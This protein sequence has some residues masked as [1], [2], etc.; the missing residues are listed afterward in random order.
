M[1]RH[2]RRLSL[3]L[4]VVALVPVALAQRSMAQNAASEDL[5][6]RQYESGLQ[7]LR[8]QKYT[9]ALKDFQTVVERY[10]GSQVAHAALLQV[11]QFYVDVARDA[12]AAKAALDSLLERYAMSESA[13]LAQV[14][15]GRVALAQSRTPSSIEAALAAF[16]RVPR[17]FPRSDAVAAALVYAGDTLRGIG[18]DEEAIQ[19]YRDASTGYP[20]SSW[21]AGALIGEARCLV[22]SGDIRRAMESLQQVRQRYPT[23]REA[24]TALAWN[25]ILYRLYLRPPIQ[26]PFRFSGKTIAGPGGKLKDV[27]AMAFAPDGTLYVVTSSGLAAFD[28]SGRRVNAPTAVEPHAIAFDDAGSAF[29]A[30]RGGVTAP[31]GRLLTLD[32]PKPDGT[33]R[34]LEEIPG[35]ALNSRG[36]ILTIDSNGRTVARFSREGTY[37]SSFSAGV[38]ERLAVDVNDTIAALGREGATVVLMNPDGTVI[39]RLTA[40]GAG[41]Q[42]ENPADLAFDP[43]GHL[44]VLDRSGR[45]VFVFNGAGRLVT[46]FSVPERAPGALRK[47][48]AFALDASG[49]LFIFDRDAERVQVYQ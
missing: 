45:C 23:S 48:T 12:G 31:G 47:P 8:E 19:R 1:V 20:E 30:R 49:R 16:D 27:E 4:A 43:F 34:V 13:P 29:V 22:R 6:R 40:K 7:F 36:E 38:A 37:L 26:P 39:R 2:A 44:Y 3:L 35:L 14:L 21:A 9:E 10:P 18:R 28:S 5:A 33:R 32:V 11:A 17:L 25:T 24:V 42:F 46:R 41:Y 15:A